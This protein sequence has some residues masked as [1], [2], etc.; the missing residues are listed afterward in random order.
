MNTPALREFNA[1]VFILRSPCLRLPQSDGNARRAPCEGRRLNDAPWLE[2]VFAR[3]I[4][5]GRAKFVKQRPTNDQPFPTSAAT[6]AAWV[7][8]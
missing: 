5:E 7:F 4:S 3:S 1:G 6:L 2:A 8:D